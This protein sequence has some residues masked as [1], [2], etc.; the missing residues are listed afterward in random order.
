MD[1]YDFCGRC[2]EPEMTEVQ[3]Y[4]LNESCKKT[5][6]IV[7]KGNMHDASLSEFKNYEVCSFDIT[8]DGMTI[9]I[10]TSDLF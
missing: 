3:I 7:Y 6:H 5:G 9:N 8:E 4:D 2:I 10:D 1:I